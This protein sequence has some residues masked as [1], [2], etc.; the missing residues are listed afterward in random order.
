M[1]RTFIRF[2][3]KSKRFHVEISFAD[4]NAMQ[5]E[6]TIFVVFIRRRNPHDDGLAVQSPERLQT[7]AFEYH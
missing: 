5:S 2:V 1:E 6:K 7:S 3:D 4:Q